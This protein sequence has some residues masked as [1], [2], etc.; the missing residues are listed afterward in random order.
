[1]SI[2]FFGGAILFS[3]AHAI[4]VLIYLVLYTV[5]LYNTIML[6]FVKKRPNFS[7]RPRSVVFLAISI[8]VI[9]HAS[10]SDIVVGVCVAILLIQTIQGIIKIHKALHNA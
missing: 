8:D 2:F 6:I 9:W 3:V 1:M 7:I 4:N 10:I 5:V